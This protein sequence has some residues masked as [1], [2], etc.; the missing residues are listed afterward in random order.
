MSTRNNCFP[1]FPSFLTKPSPDVTVL[2]KD[3]VTLPCKVAGYPQPVITWYKDDHVIQGERRQFLKINE[4]QFEDRGNY[5]CTAEN[6]LGTAR[7]TF[8]VTVKGWW[9]SE[10]R[11]LMHALFFLIRILF[12]CPG[13]IFLFFCW[14][15]Y[16]LQYGHY[17]QV[18]I[19]L[20]FSLHCSMTYR[21][22]MIH[23]WQ[24]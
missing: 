15:W 22:L 8:N 9:S 17:L 1:E 4:I 14:F 21:I 6:L 10:K 19:T 7:L 13:W 3:N 11:K 16:Y 23:A 24:I 12:L 18:K 20:R 5:T 2:E